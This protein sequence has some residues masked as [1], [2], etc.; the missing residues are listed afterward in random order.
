MF[1]KARKKE[2][3]LKGQEYFTEFL[4]KL[5]LE[6]SARIIH[7]VTKIISL[8]EDK[9]RDMKKNKE[10]ISFKISEIR[11]III[12]D[13]DLN[14]STFLDINNLLNEINSLLI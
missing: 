14:E 11:S 10:V 4:R 13:L 3:E 12:R 8:F 1:R 7:D 6:E 5:N 9:D 2:L